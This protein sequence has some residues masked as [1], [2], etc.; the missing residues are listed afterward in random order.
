MGDCPDNFASRAATAPGGIV[1]RIRLA[2]CAGLPSTLMACVP[3]QFALAQTISPT[4]PS[5]QIADAPPPLSTKPWSAA[6]GMM[7]VDGE[8]SFQAD[9]VRT[10]QD[11]TSLEQSAKRVILEGNVRI[12]LGNTTL[13]ASRAVAWVLVEVSD[14]ANPEQRLAVFIVLDEVGTPADASGTGLSGGGNSGS[15]IHASRLPVRAVV[16]ASDIAITALVKEEGEPDKA[17]RKEW[18]ELSDWSASALARSLE[19]TRREPVRA[20]V[21]QPALANSLPD[22]SLFHPQRFRAMVPG[23]DQ[24]RSRIATTAAITAPPIT[25]SV[26]SRVATPAPVTPPDGQRARSSP[27]PGTQ[28]QVQSSSAGGPVGSPVGGTIAPNALFAKS[29]MLTF[30][31]GHIAVLTSGPEP[32]VMLSDGLTFLYNDAT[33]GRLLQARAQRAVLFLAPE[34][35]AAPSTALATE[36]GAE[37]VLGVYLEGDVQITDGDL[38]LRAR[39][40]YYDL[41]ANRAVMLDATFFFVEPPRNLPLYIR[42]KEIRQESTRQFTANQV[43]FSNTAFFEPELGIGVSTATLERRERPRVAQSGEDS[44]SQPITQAQRA[45]R[46]AMYTYLTASNVTLRVNDVPFF[47]WPSYSGDP[48]QMLLKDIRFE[49]RSGSGGAARVRWNATN[50]LGLGD[51]E[52]LSLDL[53][54]DYYLER[55]PALGTR[56]T[57]ETARHLGGLTAYGVLA[58]EGQDVLKSGET[59]QQNGDFRG[60]V[61]I[62]DRFR[63]NDMWTVLTQGAYIS[64]ETFIDG[65]FDDAGQSQREFTNRLRGERTRDNT[66]LVIEARGSFN[67]FLA[68]EWLL[69][70]QGY[71]VTKLPEVSYVRQADNVFEGLP[72]VLTYFSEYRAANLQL[73]FDQVAMNQRGFSSAFLSQRVFGVDPDQSPADGLAA[74]GLTEDLITR[75]DTRHE[76]VAA[77]QAGPIRYAPFAVVRATAYDDDFEGYSS[78]PGGNDNARVW[79][80]IGMRASTTIE[81]VHDAVDSRFLDIHRLR[82]I[83]E[84]NVTVW[85]AGTNVEAKNLPVFDRDVDSLADGAAVRLGLAQML[86]T[87]RGGP[88]RWHD[89]TLLSLNTDVVFSTDDTD[90]QTSIGR[91][92]DARPERS[93]LG[94]YFVGD[95]AYRITDAT[96][97]TSSTVFDFNTNQQDLTTAG[98]LFQHEPGFSTLVDMRFLNAQDSTILTIVG[99]Y[100]ISDK[101]SFLISPNYNTTEGEVQSLGAR[102]TRKF[103]AFQASVGINYNNISGETSFS[104]VLQPYG[105]RGALGVQ[106][107]GTDLP[108]AY[109]AGGGGGL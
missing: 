49:N 100:E 20:F 55:G 27:I 75:F 24:A 21:F 70:S 54:T 87:K 79:S 50:L 36:F 18:S 13:I 103:S 51:V 47:W 16:R 61:T 42:A 68:N 3:A 89:A 19:S 108:G 69:Q 83:I 71:S 59:K 44:S 65:F 80:S 15:I 109:G 97:F 22:A 58:D 60:V 28:S 2:L 106:G 9:R 48:A 11:P 82:H 73:A 88:G 99:S 92:F 96:T 107:L 84:P 91:F 78:T 64:D 6:W 30:S 93:A 12:R 102:I 52:G 101:Y 31:A 81:R 56:A 46:E 72:G 77:L 35:G 4:A 32:A 34:K 104:F 105:A 37:Q 40:V 38:K 85:A 26:T 67:D 63:I 57:W 45:E 86:M 23:Q 74:Q 7:A 5:Q 53:Q 1:H 29:G 76:L 25:P 41:A 62:E 98:I 17:E 39:E 95:L 33:S 10:W 66:Q 90:P 94:D 14:G 43:R 8:A